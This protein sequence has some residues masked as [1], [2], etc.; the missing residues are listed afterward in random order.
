MKASVRSIPKAP[1]GLAHNKLQALL[2][3]CQVLDYTPGNMLHIL[4]DTKQQCQVVV[5]PAFDR[6]SLRYAPHPPLFWL[7][8][9]PLPGTAAT[10]LAVTPPPH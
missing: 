1:L 7:R 10:V 2:E 9:Q 6:L 5:T 8:A 4:W 3:A